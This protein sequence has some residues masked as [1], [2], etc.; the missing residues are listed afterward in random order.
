MKFLIDFVWCGDRGGNFFPDC[1]FEPLAQAVQFG[2]QRRHAQSE[3][4]RGRFVARNFNRAGEKLAQDGKPAFGSAGSFR[5]V[6]PTRTL[7][8]SQRV[9]QNYKR[10][11]PIEQEFLWSR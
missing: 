8:R 5:R 2:F 3:L 7:H 6:T 4:R 10:P 1:G 9:L 11:F